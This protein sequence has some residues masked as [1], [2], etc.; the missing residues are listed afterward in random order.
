MIKEV[1]FAEKDVQLMSSIS[2]LNLRHAC[3]LSK[4]YFRP[5]TTVRQYSFRDQSDV[6]SVQVNLVKSVELFSSLA[7]DFCLRPFVQTQTQTRSHTKRY[8][9]NISAFA[10]RV[11]RKVIGRTELLVQKEYEHGEAEDFLYALYMQG[12][13]VPGD[14]AHIRALLR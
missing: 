10:A 8:R 2:G 11:V 3:G 5:E 1:R 6:T 12:D 14:A 13:S 4:V 9:F 7:A